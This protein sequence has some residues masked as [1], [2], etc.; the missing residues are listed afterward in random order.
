MDHITFHFLSTFGALIQTARTVISNPSGKFLLLLILSMEF[1]SWGSMKNDVFCQITVDSRQIGVNLLRSGKFIEALEK[2]NNAL[3]IEPSSPELYFLRG[4]TK[5]CLDDYY[6]AEQDF[7]KSIEIAPYMSNV[8][9]F[10]AVVRSQ[11][12]DFKGAFD[13]FSTA[14]ELD[15]TN[16]EVYVNRARTNLYLKMYY[17]CLVDCNKAIK[18]K[19]PSENVYIL[20]GSAELAIGRFDNSI[21]SLNKAIAINPR[22]P[23][24][25]I[26]RGLV[27]L[28][29]VKIDS[30][31]YDF[32][33]AI[34]ADS[35]NTYAL[36]NRALAN[37]KKHE[38]KKALQDLNTVIRLSPYN[39]YAYYN[40]AIILIDMDDKPGAIRDFEIVSKLDPRNIISYYYRSKIKAE[41]KDF[42]GALEDLDKTIEL[43]PDFADAYYNR[44]LVKLKIKDRQ[45]AQE[46]YERASK[47]GKQN[48]SVSD[49]SKLKKEDYLKSLVKLSGDF[50]EMNTLNSKF[51]NQY[52]EIELIPMFKQFF[53]KADY[54]KICI[55]D[56]YQKPHYYQNL[57]MLTNHEELIHDSLA[58][59][60]IMLLTKQIDST[61][62]SP[63]L[64][65]RRAVLCAGIRNYDQ[66]FLDYDAALRLD[67][68]FI[69]V[70][71]DRAF[72]RF[73]LI[74]LIQSQENYQ[75]QIT[76]GK[77]LIQA[78]NKVKTTNLVHTY[79]MVISDLEKIIN[80][81]TGFSF[82]Y[83]NK[84]YIDC[85]MGNYRDAVTSFTKAIQNKPNFPEAFYN[86]GLLYILLNEKQKGCE[87]LSKAGELG[88]LDSYRVMKRYCY[89]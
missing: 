31:I 82:A 72:S 50:E 27:Y 79:D 47:L 36:F 64:F 12:S 81:D 34:E 25:Y 77:S 88:I 6:G 78:Q 51:Q 49:S 66:A 32:S 83:Y 9:D 7:S 61:S 73:E 17:S 76:I 35:V 60:E 10:R 68:N 84:G 52:V 18:L 1:I 63:D 14:I 24:G 55:Y 20:K 46:D 56:A 22:S 85:K 29:I 45:G 57:V 67:S 40:R 38:H 44:Y 86:R 41:L 4:Y 70:Y 54:D 48:S 23:F 26:Q 5:Y 75:E 11:L 42:R 89:K 2:I 71:F 69:L 37:I 53:G 28:D 8:F 33:M 43:F 16:A 30:A 13:D 65:Y 15:S 74:H 80:L 58:G 39:S 3:Q 62:G 59:K 19:Y 21:S 87:D